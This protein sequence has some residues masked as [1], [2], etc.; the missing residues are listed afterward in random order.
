MRQ[1]VSE[2]VTTSHRGSAADSARIP[3]VLIRSFILGLHIASGII[4]Q[5]DESHAQPDSLPTAGVS[6]VPSV[7]ELAAR[8]RQSLVV[9]RSTTRDGAD[10]GLGTGFVIDSSGLIVTARHVI[11]DGR[12]IV[13][14][15][16]DGAETRATEVYASSSRLDLAIVR[17]PA[18]S[19][20]ALAIGTSELI[21]QGRDVVAMGHPRGFRNSVVSGVISGRRDFDGVS[22]IQLAMPVEPG[23]SG[24][25]L[26]DRDGRVLGII[27]MKSTA[28]D[29][30]GFA[31]PVDLLQSLLD[32]PNPVPI[33]RWR[34]I[35]ALDSR[36]W[37]PLFGANWRQRAGRITVD[38]QGVGFGGRTLCLSTLPLPSE[39]L[40][41][42]VS[43]KLDDERG[44]AGLVFHSDGGDRHYGF[45]PSAGNLRLTRFSGP[46]VNSWT[47]LHNA[48]HATYRAGDWNTLKVRIRPDG[49]D[50]FVNGQPVVT[51]TDTELAR[52]KFG[53]A[54]FRGTRAEFR[55]FATAETLPP[56][57]PDED[58]LAALNSTSLKVTA[59]RP[60]G[61][62]VVRELLPHARFTT[63]LLTQEAGRLERLATRLRQTARDVH[64]VQVRRELL[65][66]LQLPV[67]DVAEKPDRP[68][69]TGDLLRS[70]L[71]VAQLD[72]EDVDVDSY[73]RRVDEMATE[74]QAAVSENSTPAVRLQALDKY[75]FEDNGFH[76]SR[77]E[78]Y[79]KSNSYLNEVIDDR[80][81]LPIT[82]SVLYMELAERLNLQVVGVGLPGHFVVR[83][84][85]QD[86]PATTQLIDPFEKGRRLSLDDA[87]QRLRDAGHPNLP[88]F[89]EA[90]T[91][92]QI[93][94][95]M[96]TNLLS[97]AEAGRSDED[98][99]RYLEV[100]TELSPDQ[101]EYRARRVEMRARTG[102]LEDA[103]LDVD[104]FLR[105][106]PAG[107]DENRLHELRATLQQQLNLR[108]D[109]PAAMP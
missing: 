97:L 67:E 12:D 53:L 79:T 17:I 32:D 42:Q 96:L 83:Y 90:Q 75:L 11:G 103:I 101:F 13:V 25:P 15:L 3:A 26:V 37:S 76:G 30:L 89:Y 4:V 29:N 18:S 16:P 20:P 19:L 91:S 49:F 22:M 102:R 27:T 31:L 36:S 73:V 7:T 108:Q 69:G 71:L 106:R 59:D 94:Q 23:N 74:I 72:N 63:E 68:P 86:D 78:Y 80:E 70:A 50:C 34:T 41:L 85:P 87:A 65:R 24:G 39:L 104:W 93:I 98:V 84:E 88:A 107:T 58:V 44:A 81:G 100:L 6:A 52:G 77:F 40:E 47:I 10:D 43:V 105:V 82:L 62:E 66:E 35:G 57:R 28:S 60:A 48:P 45:Y 56:D 33:Q 46:D 109:I 95:R 92:V 21:S 8:V 51:S 1:F 54:S 5:G 61:A 9:V 55:G 14:E 38:G 64:L 2:G 99:R